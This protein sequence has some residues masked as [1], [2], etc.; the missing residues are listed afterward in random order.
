MLNINEVNFLKELIE[1]K[2]SCSLSNRL[3]NRVD[4]VWTPYAHF[5]CPIKGCRPG[6]C[7]LPS[8]TEIAAKLLFDHEVEETLS[9]VE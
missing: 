5:E 1:C 9:D 2:G 6:K 7:F 4:C 8:R 3:R